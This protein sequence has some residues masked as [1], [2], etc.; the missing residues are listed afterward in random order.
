[1]FKAAPPSAGIAARLREFP[2]F[3]RLSPQGQEEL[4][5]AAITRHL[6]RGTPLLEEGQLCQVLLLMERGTLRIFQASPSD[7]E[8]R[9][10]TS[11]LPWRAR[12]RL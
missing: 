5:R 7:E 4:L 12:C 3:P 1:M 9:A 6:A 10:G 2:F 8:K 11:A